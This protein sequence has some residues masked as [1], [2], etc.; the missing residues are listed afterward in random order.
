MTIIRVSLVDVYVVRWK[1]SALECLGLRRGPGGRC[2]GSWE[3]VHGHIDADEPPETA[4]IREVEEETGL[5][6][7]HLYNLSRVELFYQH[8]LNEV[9]LIPVFVALVR[10]D[11]VVRLSPEHDM[12]AWLTLGSARQRLAWPRERRALDDVEMLLG[13]GHAG[14]VDDVLRVC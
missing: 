14:Q 7:L 2:P 6:P 3:S 1:G 11:A 8:R 12:F 10:E 9:A 4:A 5:S 13:Q